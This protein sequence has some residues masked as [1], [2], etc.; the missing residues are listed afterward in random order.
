M[1]LKVLCVTY[2]WRLSL[3]QDCEFLMDKTYLLSLQTQHQANDWYSLLGQKLFDN[4]WTM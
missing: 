4:Q 3:H 2:V 1:S